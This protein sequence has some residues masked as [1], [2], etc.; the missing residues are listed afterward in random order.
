[1]LDLPEAFRRIYELLSRKTAYH[2]LHAYV[3]QEQIGT[4]L[5]VRPVGSSPKLPDGL[6]LDKAHG[7]AGASEV[8][9]V[10][11]VVLVG[12]QGGEPSRPYIA[13]YLASTPVSVTVDAQTTITLGGETAVPVALAPAVQTALVVIE[14][15]GAALGLAT[16]IGQ[17]AAAGTQLAA[18]IGAITEVAATKVRAE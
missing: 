5:T 7:I 2:P 8:C 3:V 14:T 12:F 17:A 6:A 4:R 1:M 9:A 11:S 16:T 18:D 10:G 13:G 15:F